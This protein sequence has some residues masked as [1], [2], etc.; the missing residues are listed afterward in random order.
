[1]YSAQR[2]SRKRVGLRA[3][4][5]RPRRWASALR[6]LARVVA[7]ALDARSRDRARRSA[8][9]SS[10]RARR[11]AARPRRARTCDRAGGIR[12]RRG[13]G[14]PGSRA[15]RGSRSRRRPCRRRRAARCGGRSGRRCR[16]ARC[17]RRPGDERP[18]QSTKGMPPKMI[19]LPPTYCFGSRSIMNWLQCTW[20]V[21]SSIA[22]RWMCSSVMVR[23]RLCSISVPGS[24]SSK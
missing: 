17:R 16:R 18:R 5:P 12:R 9:S 19:S 11:R 10:P 15:C 8:S 20:L 3:S 13:P 24:K 2:S 21:L 14:G 22:V 7:A 4:E 1:M 6:R 23:P